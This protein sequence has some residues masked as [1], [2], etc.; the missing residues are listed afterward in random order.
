METD[1]VLNCWEFKNCGREKGGSKVAELGVCPASTDESLDK[2]N[3]GKNAGRICWYV[4]GTLCRGVKQGT[5]SQ[6]VNSCVECDFL[7]L[8]RKEEGLKGN[9]LNYLPHFD[10]KKNSNN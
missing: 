6:K 9:T 1:N 3:S 2:Q 8:V 4:A 7:M 5:H 10:K